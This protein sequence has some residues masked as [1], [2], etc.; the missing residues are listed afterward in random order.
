MVVVAALGSVSLA[1][2]LLPSKLAAGCLLL[3]VLELLTLQ[4]VGMESVERVHGPHAWECL[5][6]SS[7]FIVLL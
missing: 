6:S 7:S 3:S 5:V 2:S 4:M 1:L